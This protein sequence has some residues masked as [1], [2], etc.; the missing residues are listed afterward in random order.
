MGVRKARPGAVTI[1]EIKPNMILYE[2]NDNAKIE[3]TVVNKAATAKKGTLVALMHLDL[4]T[5]REIK[6]EA[7]TLESGATKKWKVNYEENH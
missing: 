7:V 4:D 5:V 3:A 6:S 2:E 1:T